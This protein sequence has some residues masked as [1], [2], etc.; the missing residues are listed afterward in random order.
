MNYSTPRG[1]RGQVGSASQDGWVV[2]RY[3]VLIGKYASQKKRVTPDPYQLELINATQSR[4]P[5]GV[6]GQKSHNIW[7]ARKANFLTQIFSEAKF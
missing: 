6:S 1:P 5:K 4:K 7:R 2:S 3:G